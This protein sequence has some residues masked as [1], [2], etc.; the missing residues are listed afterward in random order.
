M[1][2]ERIS[3]RGCE[4]GRVLWKELSMQVAH[5]SRLLLSSREVY[6]KSQW[7]DL[8]IESKRR[9]LLVRRGG[10]PVLLSRGGTT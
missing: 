4:E 2:G 8:I 1:S 7:N 9:Y 6:S 10:P 5:V 3:L